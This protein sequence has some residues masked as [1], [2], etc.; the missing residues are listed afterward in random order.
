MAK[1][2]E[3]NDGANQ[4][5][6]LDEQRLQQIEARR[7]ATM[8][9]AGAATSNFIT[10]HTLG[11]D[12]TLSHLALKYYGH[13]TPPYWRLIYDANKDMIGDN[14]NF[15]HQGMIIK[16]PVLPEGFKG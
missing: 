10:E 5:D 8:A 2:N 14:P 6:S 13:A 4:A 12:E 15:V 11:V 1:E 9:A 3:N 16:I 7:A